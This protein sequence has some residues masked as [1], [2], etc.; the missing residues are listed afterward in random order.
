[1]F[2]STSLILDADDTVIAGMYDAIPVVEFCGAGGSLRV[3]VPH[4]TPEQATTWLR[5]LAVAAEELAEQIELDSPGVALAKRHMAEAMA[6]A[7]IGANPDS[8]E[9]LGMSR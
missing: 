8:H 3:H 6:A 7:G 1:M 5:S 4:E 2:H 9:W